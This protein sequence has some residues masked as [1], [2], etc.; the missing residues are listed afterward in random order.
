MHIANVANSGRAAGITARTLVEFNTSIYSTIKAGNYNSTGSVDI[1]GWDIT[2]AWPGT[3]SPSTD[4]AIWTVSTYTA[5]DV[6]ATLIDDDD[7]QTSGYV[8]VTTTNVGQPPQSS[9]GKRALSRQQRDIKNSTTGWTVCAIDLGRVD[10]SG[11][12][13]GCEQ[14]L[15]EDCVFDLQSAAMEAYNVK[16][17]CSSSISIPSSSLSLGDRNA[18]DYSD[19]TIYGSVEDGDR[20]I[21]QLDDYTAYDR[22]ATDAHVTLLIWAGTNKTVT[23]SQQ[24]AVA[25]PR[26][27]VAVGASRTPN[28][29]M[30]K[31]VSS[32]PLLGFMLLFI[33]LM[34]I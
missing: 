7:T 12:E 5:A 3:G 6:P 30:S 32:K 33:F 1:R 17:S 26:S 25:C 34:V 8:T 23:S 18:S 19:F 31:H 16:K 27:T 14:A 21:H 22:A 15:G 9:A 29:S 13:G 4:L 20:T 11:D 24:V 10:A 2:Q 28:A